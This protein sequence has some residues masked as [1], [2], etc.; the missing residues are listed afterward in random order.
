[1]F[2]INPVLIKILIYMQN[3]NIFYYFEKKNIYF[4]NK[5]NIININDSYYYMTIWFNYLLIFIFFGL[6][7]VIKCT[8]YDSIFTYLILTFFTI[9][10]LIKVY[11]LLHFYINF[12]LPKNRNKFM[13]FFVFLI[14]FLLNLYLLVYTFC[15]ILLINDLI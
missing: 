10:L 7:I 1:M 13:F 9:I 11:F 5:F 2:F 3:N 12:K 14:D 4:K 15:G 8:N 6:D